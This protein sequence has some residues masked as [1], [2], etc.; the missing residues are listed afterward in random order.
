MQHNTS[1]KHSTTQVVRT[2]SGTFYACFSKYDI[3]CHIETSC[4][5]IFTKLELEMHQEK[6]LLHP[7]KEALMKSFFEGLGCVIIQKKETGNVVV[8]FCRL[9]PLT[10]H[11][12]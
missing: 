9:I 6:H 8:G 12:G 2:A 1:S 11:N 3:S 7:N 5:E 4:D 10:L